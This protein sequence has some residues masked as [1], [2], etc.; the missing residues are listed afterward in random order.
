MGGIGKKLP[1]ITSPKEGNS[2]IKPKFNLV[3]STNLWSQSLNHAANTP[4]SKDFDDTVSTLTESVH[5]KT[6]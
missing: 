1:L 2:L 5:E 3:L 4:S 6:A